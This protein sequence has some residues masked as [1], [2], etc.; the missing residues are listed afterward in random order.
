MKMFWDFEKW[1]FTKVKY[2]C[3]NITPVW[4]LF[5]Q[6]ERKNSTDLLQYEEDKCLIVVEKYWRDLSHKKTTR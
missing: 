4:Q 2:I 3:Q 1:T 6:S 5:A